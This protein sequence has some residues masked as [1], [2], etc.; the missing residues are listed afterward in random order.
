MDMAVLKVRG[1][2]HPKVP[3]SVQLRSFFPAQ[4]F[5]GLLHLDFCSFKICVRLTRTQHVV[6]CLYSEYALELELSE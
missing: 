1:R 3:V 6:F 4:T 2:V 5:C